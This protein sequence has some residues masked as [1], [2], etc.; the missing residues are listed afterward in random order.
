MTRRHRTPVPAL[1]PLERPHTHQW[2][3]N[4]A[5][6]IAPDEPG[7]D[8]QAPPFACDECPATATA[9]A[10]CEQPS[11]TGARVCLDCVSLARTDLLR[12]RDL[13]LSMSDVVADLGGLR[14]VRYDSAGGGK[15]GR[16][17]ADTTIL[18]GEALVLSAGGSPY[19][20]RLGRWESSVD[21]ALLAAERHD[22]P[23][24]FAIL[25]GWAI[26][27]AAERDDRID[28][29]SSLKTAA[30][31]LHE[32][33]TWAAEHSPTW[34]DYRRAIN[35]LLWRLRRLAGEIQPRQQTEPVP[36]VHCGGRVIRT[37]SK[38]GLSDVRTC[39]GCGSS[40]PN[41]ERLRHIESQVVF[42]LPEGTPDALVTI[43]EAKMIYRGR[44][45]SDR[46]D[47]WAKSLPPARGADGQPMHDEAGRALYRL[48]VIDGQVKSGA[49]ESSA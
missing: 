22:P 6:A 26:A 31:Y 40:W 29:P 25:S 32:H 9:C 21:A 28:P 35:D 11:Q 8:P 10:S 37:W 48:G 5:Y 2:T 39:Q 3:A 27:W 47:A 23:S 17:R 45:R 1:S 42:A 30:A 46:F 38:A 24:A 12:V 4:P 16:K 34:Q 19:P 15:P 36:C 43:D 44:V 18:G 7:F 14:A 49:K 33:T 13:T 20:P 41:E